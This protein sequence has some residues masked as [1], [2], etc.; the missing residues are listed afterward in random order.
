MKEVVSSSVLDGAMSLLGKVDFANLT[1]DDAKTLLEASSKSNELKRLVSE[2][3][4][5]DL[6]VA[7]PTAIRDLLLP[8]HPGIAAKVV[9]LDAKVREAAGNVRKE[10][11][12]IIAHCTCVQA[13][14][15]PGSKA[16]AAR[17][18]NCRSTIERAA[19]W[20]VFLKPSVRR[21]LDSA[22]QS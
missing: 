15:M 17:A 9:L 3:N 12:Y 22:S 2:Y 8:L 19:T 7:W 6:A 16:A 1:Q 11:Q 4:E 14:L 21:A 18:D 13:L 20:G 5:W 10:A